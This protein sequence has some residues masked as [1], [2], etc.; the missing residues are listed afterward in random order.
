MS[1]QSRE[2]RQSSLHPCTIHFFAR[3]AE[4]VLFLE[5]KGCCQTFWGNVFCHEKLS[6]CRVLPAAGRWEQQR[7]RLSHS[8]IPAPPAPCSCVCKGFTQTTED[9]LFKA[10]SKLFCLLI[11][12]KVEAVHSQSCACEGTF[13]HDLLFLLP[14]PGLPTFPPVS[15]CVSGLFCLVFM[16]IKLRESGSNHTEVLIH[17]FKSSS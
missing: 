8:G 14:H 2:H 13:G 16:S 11:L 12:R 1:H 17:H 3:N 4:M 7:E 10:P 5:A 15:P 6:G 9:G